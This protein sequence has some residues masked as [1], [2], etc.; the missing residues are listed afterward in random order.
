MQAA[1]AKV[2]SALSLHPRKHV[3]VY[4]TNEQ[5]LR[6]LRLAIAEHEAM[7]RV[8]PMMQSE[9]PEPAGAA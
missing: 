3:T 8:T 4:A 9:K 6:E 5:E 1:R 7:T 2:Q